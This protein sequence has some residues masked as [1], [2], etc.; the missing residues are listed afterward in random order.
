MSGQ[1]DAT[2][3]EIM[4]TEIVSVGPSAT[5]AEAATLM[6]KRH[7]G[8][9]LV[10]DGERVVGI[11]TERD[12]VRALAADFDAAGHAVADW[13]TAQPAT[14]E[15]DVPVRQALDRMLAAGYRHLPVVE[16]GST[17]GIVSI[18]DLSRAAVE[19]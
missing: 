9:A 2:V 14:V 12:I 10:M 1:R 19:R 13:M 3:R 7:V 8:S 11:F 6:G 4:S 16:G 5:V 15:P 17:V 18:R